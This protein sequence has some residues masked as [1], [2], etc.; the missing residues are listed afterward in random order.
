MP[1]SCNCRGLARPRSIPSWP[2][3]KSANPF[4]SVCGRRLASPGGPARGGMR[5]DDDLAAIAQVHRVHNRVGLLNLG[6]KPQEI[7][8]A[9]RE[10]LMT[11]MHLNR[12]QPLHQH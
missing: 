3:L 6:K 5:V 11:E 9:L 4:R 7:P 1:A 8:E 10:I 2:S 12:R